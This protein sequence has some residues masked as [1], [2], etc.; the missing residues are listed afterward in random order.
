MRT[1]ADK[2]SDKESKG[3]KNETRSGSLE[4]EVTGEPPDDVSSPRKLWR[5]LDFL[6]L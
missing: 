1:A 4:W 6:N 5:T 3:D 2:S